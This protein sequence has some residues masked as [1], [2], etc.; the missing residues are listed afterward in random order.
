M[1][2]DIKHTEIITTRPPA[3]AEGTS[4]EH[5]KEN[6]DKFKPKK[7]EIVEML[8]KEGWQPSMIDI[9]FDELQGF[10]RWSCQINKL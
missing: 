4:I 7:V 3:F 5:G 6:I 8:N 1:T 2:I 9:W 10:W